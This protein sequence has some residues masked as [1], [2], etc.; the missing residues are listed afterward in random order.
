MKYLIY[1][2]K[3]T[4]TED[5]QVLSLDSQ[6]SELLQLAQAH[7]LEVSEI[8]R[9]SMSAKSEGRPI[10]G[11]V[12]S[13]IK[14]GKADGI[15]CWKLDRLARNFIDGGKIIDLLQKVEKGASGRSREIS[16]SVKKKN[17]EVK[18]IGE[19]I[20]TLVSTGDGVAGA[21]I[22]LMIDGV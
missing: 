14:E 10:F 18:F 7:N 20:I 19:P 1:C 4:D 3:S 12:L 17:R 22:H 2:R 16:I 21:Q 11:K 8:Y 9:E 13:L 5:K 15:I 6:E